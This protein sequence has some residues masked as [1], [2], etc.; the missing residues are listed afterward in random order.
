[1]CEKS[2]LA[3]IRLHGAVT[4]QFIILIRLL[5]FSPIPHIHKG[6]M[7]RVV[8]H[9]PCRTNTKE[10]QMVIPLNINRITHILAHTPQQEL[11]G[12]NN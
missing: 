2:Q 5:L 8:E 12:A 11:D 9:N 10:I 7:L 6:V 1:M 3:G 4:P